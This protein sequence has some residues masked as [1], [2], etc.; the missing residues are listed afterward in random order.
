MPRSLLTVLAILAIVSG[1]WIGQAP[2]ASAHETD[3]F[4][5][6]EEGRFADL[7][8]VLNKI[9]VDAMRDGAADL[10]RRIRYEQSREQPDEQTLAYLR[11]PAAIARAVRR[12]LPGAMA[13]I[14][15]LEAQLRKDSFRE[16]Y[17][18][19]HTIYKKHFEDGMHT[20]LH[21]WYDVRVVSR[22]WR[23]GTIRVYDT[24]LGTDKIGHLIDMGYRYYQKYRQ[25]RS[26]DATVEEAIERVV[27]YGADDPL[28]GE[29]TVLGKL[30]SG[31][32]SNADM[33]ANYLGFLMFRN[34]TETVELRGEPS[35]QTMRLD[36][37]GRWVL[38]PQVREA[39]HAFF[40]RYIDDHLNEAL[41]PSL[42]D[43]SM[44]PRAREA[45]ADRREH[46]VSTWYTDEDGRPR[47]AG[48]FTMK[49]H[50]LATYYGQDYGHSG[51]FDALVHLGNTVDGDDPA[52]A[53]QETDA[54]DDDAGGPGS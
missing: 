35:P 54:Q 30:S 23:S 1:C 8:P 10:N 9:I 3:Q 52:L 33:A 11:S 2:P 46:L 16:L 37:E 42:F 27:D 34:L 20:G 43:K 7:G 36:D 40:A 50:E 18:G 31:A 47:P 48:W 25:A 14:E 28:V 29:T 13:M 6:P 41:N 38:A 15:G 19:R 51:E 45:V 22:I 39:G 17:P 53:E 21:A 49:V 32:Y 5:M 44:R 12:E 4:L 24:Y 26:A